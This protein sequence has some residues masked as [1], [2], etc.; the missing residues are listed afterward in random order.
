MF[1]ITYTGKQI[2]HILRYEITIFIVTSSKR[3]YIQKPPSHPTLQCKY[4]DRVEPGM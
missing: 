2:K 4:K 1:Y 3:N